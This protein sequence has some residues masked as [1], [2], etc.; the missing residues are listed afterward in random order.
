MSINN[1]FGV[2]F[3]L[4][5][6]STLI[7]SLSSTS[8]KLPNKTFIAKQLNST[9]KKLGL[10]NFE[11]E[12]LVVKALDNF[13]FE[14]NNLFENILQEKNDDSLDDKATIFTREVIKILLKKPNLAHILSCN[15][16]YSKVEFSNKVN[17]INT[18]IYFIYKRI[19]NSLNDKFSS[20]CAR[21]YTDL[22]N[23]IFLNISRNIANETHQ[24]LITEIEAEINNEINLLK[25][26][27]KKLT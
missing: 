13:N 24:G 8:T 23:G 6:N 12:D 2:T 25:V 5:V 19:F 17:D 26:L 4:M 3:E 1:L 16:C 7:N 20:A 21:I 27:M 11:V 18:S 15:N 22:L 10:T 9:P 14:C